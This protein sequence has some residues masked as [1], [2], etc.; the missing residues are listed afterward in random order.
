MTARGY[1]VISISVY[2]DDLQAIDAFVDASPGLD[3][4]KLLRC[5]FA[6][7]G[8]IPSQQPIKWPRESG[9]AA[10]DFSDLVQSTFIAGTGSLPNPPD[11]RVLCPVCRGI[12]RLTKRGELRAHRHGESGMAHSRA[13]P[14]CRA[15]GLSPEVADRRRIQLQ[16]REAA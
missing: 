16:P 9:R 11:G 13:I 1:R 5:A 4:S 10:R 8:I 2:E 12:V 3:R 6:A 14:E 15:S 7:V